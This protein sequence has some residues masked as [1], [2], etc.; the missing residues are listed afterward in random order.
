M[1]L[2]ELSID[3]AHVQ[4]AERLVSLEGRAYPTLV[5]RWESR[6]FDQP[7]TT[8]VVLDYTI[9]LPPLTLGNATFNE[10]RIAAFVGGAPTKFLYFGTEMTANVPRVGP[11]MENIVAP[12][13]A[14]QE[15]RLEEQS[16]P[17]PYLK[18]IQATP[19]IY[20]NGAQDYYSPPIKVERYDGV[21]GP[22]HIADFFPTVV[23][24]L[25]HVRG[26]VLTDSSRGLW[27]GSRFVG[28]VAIAI[29]RQG[30][31]VGLHRRMGRTDKDAVPPEVKLR[32]P[33]NDIVRG[34]WVAIDVGAASTVIALRG[35]RGAGEFI[36][37]GATS[38]V[39]VPA[40]FETPSE[41]AFENLARAI[42]AWRDRVILP[43]TRWEDVH[44]GFAAKAQRTRPG[45][46]QPERGTAVIPQVPLLRERVERKD[47]FRL[48]G[49]GD[50]DTSE[51]L[52][53]PAPPII[54]EEGIGAHDPFDPIELYAYYVGLHVNQRSRGIYT[55]YAV[56]M[57]TGW[58]PERRTSVLIAFRRGLFRSLPAG[59][60]EYHDLDGLQVVDAGPAAVAFAV[61]A[62]RMFG[63][64]PR[65]DNVPFCAID[66]GASETG[67]V[68]GILRSAKQDERDTH[69]IERMVEYLEPTSIPWL[70]GERLLH[71]L[72]YRVYGANEALMRENDIPMERPQ[73]EPPL[74]AFDSLLLSTNPEA[75]ANT[76]ILKDVLR[77]LLEA[78]SGKLKLGDKIRLAGT[79]GAP[80]ELVLN[81]EREPLLKAIED[82]FT[83]GV[84]TFHV[85][86][87]AALTKIGR[88]PNPY[89]GLHVILGGRMGL[90]PFL[91][92]QLTHELPQGVKFHRFREP[93]GANLAAPTVKTAC[94]LG[95]LA[96][97]LDRVGAGL[98]GEKRD[99]FRFRVGRN[100]HGQLA[101]VLDPAVD[102]DT[103]REM[104]AATKPDVE[105]LFMPAEDDGEVAADDPRVQRAVC[106]FGAVAVGRRLYARAV[107]PA[108]V[109]VSIGPPGGEPEK[110]APRFGVDL[111]TATAE[112]LRP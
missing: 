92:E 78:P 13:R 88:D 7:W 6:L 42:K 93:D 102:Y 62:F 24:N 56:T 23:A 55:R 43:M 87:E 107:G 67:I 66:A 54:D 72:A 69:N 52:R 51:A 60:L 59:M 61:H 12:T 31:V 64:A 41:I 29:L 10:V 21:A 112:L 44:V 81:I 76:Q 105:V 11:E 46:D 34:G 86:L 32:D 73:E 47:L 18:L 103:W 20:G 48:R 71:R 70:G 27:Q 63:I 33:K 84:L 15:F 8:T 49:R 57:P 68:F 28:V 45:P 26:P 4:E 30:K 90:H 19:R 37:I 1:A 89:D 109:E 106:P 25:E 58:S 38:P 50:P 110:G 82:W 2:Y 98:R 85:A 36:R 35:D 96:M 101:D 74:P 79:D 22:E 77:P 65:G 99:A 14:Y 83:E 104:G 75:R 53:R 108:R 91:Y 95:V 111:K 97:K 5:M 39:A 40:D 100:R 80:R 9:S 17:V 3:R 94:A 16:C